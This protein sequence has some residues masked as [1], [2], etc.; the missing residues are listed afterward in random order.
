M[1]SLSMLKPD[2]VDSPLASRLKANLDALLNDDVFQKVISSGT[3]GKG[4]IQTRIEMAK[5]AVRKAAPNHAFA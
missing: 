5:M 1:T 3:N 4:A 2:R